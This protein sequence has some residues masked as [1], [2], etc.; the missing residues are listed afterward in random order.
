MTR[1]LRPI[2][3]ILAV[4]PS[5]AAGQTQMQTPAPTG[6]LVIKWTAQASMADQTRVSSISGAPIAS[7][8]RPELLSQV[9][10]KSRRPLATLNDL[11]RWSHLTPAD[12]SPEALR[13]LAVRLQ[14]DPA[15]E[16][17]FLEP[18]MVPA[19]LGF[20]AFTGQ[21]PAITPGPLTSDTP[22][23]TDLQ[24]YLDPAPLGIGARAVWPH[25]GARGSTV[26]IIDIEGGWLWA[27][28][29]LPVPF[30]D[31][32]E[33]IDEPVWRNH[34]T[35]VV[36]VMRGEPNE[37]GVDGIVPECQVGNSSIGDQ[38]LAEALVSAALELEVGDIVLIELHAPGP[39]SIP[40]AGQYGY[41]PMEF[42]QDNFETIRALSD[43]GIIVVEAAGN[44]QQD[45]DDPLYLDLFNPEVRHSGAIMVGATSGSDLD[46]AWFTN[47]GQRVDLCGWGM[48]VVTCAYGDLQGGEDETVWYTAMFSGT[49]SASPIVTGAV[50][51]LQGMVE[52][53]LG[54]SLDHHLARHL[55]ASTG[56]PTTGPELIGPRP[57]LEGALIQ[58]AQGIGIIEGLVTD[59]DSGLP[60]SGVEVRV[61]PDGPIAYTASDG[62][63]RL[64]LMA[65]D[66]ELR[67]L[68]Y[69]HE[70]QDEFVTV[71]N[72]IV[73]HTTQLITLPLEIIHG[74]VFDNEDAML[75]GARLEL[76]DE[77]VP[78]TYSL[79]DGTY[80]FEPVP[81]GMPHRLMTGGVPL[82]GGLIVEFPNVTGRIDI[83]FALPF[84]DSDFEDDPDGFTTTGDLW[85]HGR[86]DVTGMGPGTAFSGD[87][88]WGVGLDGLGYPDETESSLHSPVY[89]PGQ[90]N[91][92][93]LHLSFHYWSGTEP[94]FD[95]V[96]LVFEREGQ[97]P[98]ILTPVDGYT[99]LFLGALGHTPGWSGDS[100]GWRTV[101]FDVS[102]GLLDP[103]SFTLR[104]AS[105]ASLNAEGFLIDGITLHDF[106]TFIGVENQVPTVAGAQLNA[107]PNPFNPQVTLAWEFSV[108]GPIDLAVFDL[109]GRL[110]RHLIAGES[111][112][113]RGHI[114]WNGTNGRGQAL[115]S[116]I[117]LVRAVDTLGH[118]T[119]RRITLAR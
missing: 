27:H 99:D 6:R 56:T 77:P 47:N 97:E 58:A 32:G 111:V 104:F 20:D 74:T 85:E 84:I 65:H 109:R 16:T 73:A 107:W 94:G 57:D 45:L 101:I 90:F 25:A 55:L 59:A 79:A 92:N 26:K 34:G 12:T 14:H 72:G 37:Y 9:A 36:G 23:Y 35:A 66:Y 63:Y 11:T 5:I 108:P 10:T 70:Q 3:L 8:I 118:T 60:V 103:W 88:C 69:Y 110:V 68:S 2:L 78:V 1:F 30:A 40:G 115:P 117:Y 93:R 83:T 44:G 24:G 52:A 87:W 67:F 102:E 31:I 21:G 18:R 4:L 119:T 76:I 116:G 42:W 96:Q 17:A 82:Y 50:A 80:T 19:A 53:D 105:D 86:P 75:E 100:E 22:D 39:N 46:P 33:H 62:T 7:R 114:N 64:G 54:F 51:A 113:A 95:G 38:S 71:T 81:E 106:D 41:L 13:R 89:Q 28:E 91:H 112:A 98:E 43:L 29:D 49:S 15:V 48:D 61:M